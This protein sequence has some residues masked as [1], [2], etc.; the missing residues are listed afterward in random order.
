MPGPL[1]IPDQVFHAIR[2]HVVT[3]VEH[4]E[5]GY[6]SAQEEEDTITGELGGAL[7]TKATQLV[8]VTDGQVPGA[9]RW[10]ITYSKFRSKARDAT[11][12]IVGADG[13]LEMRVG[14][15][16][17]DQRKSALFQ[18][19]NAQRRDSNLVEQCAKMSVWREASFVIHYTANGYNAYSLDAILVSRGS[20][21]QAHHGAPLASWI[22]DTF[23]GCRIGHPDL[24]YDKDERKLY[25]LREQSS[26][27]EYR[28]DRWV[29]VDFSP[30]H[31]VHIDVTPP[32]RERSRAVEIKPKALSLSRLAFTSSD[33][34]GIEA[35]FTLAQLKRR[36][37]EL[38]RAYH[39]DI[40]YHL[41]GDLR[42]LLDARVVEI[43]K[44]FTEL[45]RDV[46][47]EKKPPNTQRATKTTAS[48]A[49]DVLH[50]P[51]VDEMFAKAKPHE[52]V[53]V[54]RNTARPRHTS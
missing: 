52:R 30:K 31:L 24:Y 42:A 18:A 14:S 49:L 23:I 22:V 13:I 6:P 33:L 54:R 39:S 10:S 37:A 19:K 53:K 27:E 36:K 50:T 34:F 26:E 9:W 17:R 12:S 20:I 16:E 40:S 47:T 43:M 2:E 46:V 3:A 7:R 4:A 44:A 51:T 29:C 8:Y 15:P 45:A 21:A 41:S 11:E 35:P 5:S 1:S 38:L 32:N 25:W 28:A 48:T